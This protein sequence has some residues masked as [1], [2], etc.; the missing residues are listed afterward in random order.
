MG[1]VLFYILAIVCV[2]GL[3]AVPIAFLVLA[4]KKDEYTESED[5]KVRLERVHTRKRI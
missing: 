5:E 2:V 4:F 3:I 1:F